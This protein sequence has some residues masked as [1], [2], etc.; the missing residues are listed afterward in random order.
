MIV[1]APPGIIGTYVV[2]QYVEE[3][4]R[5]FEVWQSQ[6]ARILQPRSNVVA[7]CR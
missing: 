6:L 3:K 5:G 2:Y 1:N 4:R 7:L